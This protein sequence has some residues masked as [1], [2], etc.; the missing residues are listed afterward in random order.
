MC[1]WVLRRRRNIIRLQIIM[2]AA[3]EIKMHG[4]KFTMNDVTARLHI[5]KTSLYGYFPS[6][7]ALVAAVIKM[8][9]EDVQRQEEDIYNDSERSIEDKFQA[10]MSVSPAL[11]GPS[12]DS[13]YYDLQT[14]YPEQWRNVENFRQQR[15]DRLIALL[16]KGVSSR[17]IK[18]INFSVLK[19]LVFFSMND[20]FD[21]TFLVEN[22]MTYYDAV[23]SL[24]KILTR[25]FIEEKDI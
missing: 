2:A 12:S 5:S 17:K 6:K 19:Q 7:S 25:G 20:L 11:V 23:V 14:T 8:V 16:E 13:I 1:Y 21:H 15:L 24:S 9:Q 10:V 18:P 22:N 3:A 4:F